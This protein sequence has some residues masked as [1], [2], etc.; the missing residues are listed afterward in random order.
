MISLAY[1]TRRGK[2]SLG[3]LDIEGKA[4]FGET[5]VKAVEGVEGR[6]RWTKEVDIIHSNR[7]TV[8]T[9]NT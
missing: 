1:R 5:R 6:N 2:E 9:L 8:K 7:M 4:C 3:F